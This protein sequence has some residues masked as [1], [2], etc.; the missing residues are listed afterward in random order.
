MQRHPPPLQGFR[1][2]LVLLGV[3]VLLVGICGGTLLLVVFGA[4]DQPAFLRPVLGITL[5]L[6]CI[7]G[8][9]G[10]LF[11]APLYAGRKLPLRLRILEVIRW[12]LV[13]L[14]FIVEPLAFGFTSSFA[15]LVREIFT[16][17]AL[18]TMKEAFM[19]VVLP[20]ILI[21]WVLTCIKWVW[22]KRQPLK[23]RIAW[24]RTRVR[25]M[26]QTWP[27]SV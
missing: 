4:T 3:F 7:L 6:A 27:R 21:F 23:T 11:Y 19:Q 9:L 16:S 5:P 18:A 10:L 2:F 15:D 20:G 22:E 8:G 25:H 24:L 13:A 26:W 17:E 14:F 12:E 1:L